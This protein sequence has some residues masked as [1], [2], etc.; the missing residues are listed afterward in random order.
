MENFEKLL[1]QIHQF[2]S[3]FVVILGDFNA[4]SKSWWN[5]DIA[6]NGVSQIN[7]LATAYGLQQLISDTTNILSNSTTCIDV[8]FTDQANLVVESGV[9]P[10]LNTNCHH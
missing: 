10:S 7:S 6:P 2:R 9:N 5:E 4:R 3:F 8:I 1:Y